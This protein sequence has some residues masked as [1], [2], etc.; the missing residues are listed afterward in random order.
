MH[1]TYIRE[2]ERERERE[3]DV[4]KDWFA[5]KGIRYATGLSTRD[6]LSAH[7]AQCSHNWLEE[8]F[9]NRTT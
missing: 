9:G 1:Q 3:R 5:W 2:R 7:L 4:E 8:Q 6:A